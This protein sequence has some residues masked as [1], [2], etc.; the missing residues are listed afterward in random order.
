[1]GSI[2]DF[3]PDVKKNLFRTIQ[4]LRKMEGKSLL[5][6]KIKRNLIDFF[7]RRCTIEEIYLQATM[8]KFPQPAR[9]IL[10]KYKKFVR[11]NDGN[12][13]TDRLK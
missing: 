1:M 9:R 11:K 12:F 6:Q 3:F 2:Q 13:L 4:N 7:H 8:Q 10:A 5:L